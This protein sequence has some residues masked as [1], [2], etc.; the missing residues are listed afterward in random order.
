MKGFITDILF[1]LDE[2]FDI[3]HTEPFMLSMA[4]RGKNTNGSQ[5]FMYVFKGSNCS[6]VST[7]VDFFHFSTLAPAP[8][9]DG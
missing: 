2:S 5:F 7:K 4:N 1:F 6:V 8:H 3:K 9:L